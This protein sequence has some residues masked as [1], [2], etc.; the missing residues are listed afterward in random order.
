M[1]ISMSKTMSWAVHERARPLTVTLLYLV[2]GGLYAAS[3][4]MTRIAA[5]LHALQEV[6]RA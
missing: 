2:A 4:K 5:R 6:R 3:E 1:E